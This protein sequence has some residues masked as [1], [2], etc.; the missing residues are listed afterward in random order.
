MVSLPDNPN[1]TAVINDSNTDVGEISDGHSGVERPRPEPVEVIKNAA[2]LLLGF[3]A[4]LLAGIAAAFVIAEILRALSSAYRR[5]LYNKASPEEKVRMLSDMIFKALYLR[6]IDACFGWKVDE[7]DEIISATVDGVKP[8]E[9]KRIVAIIEKTVYGG[10]APDGFE[11][12]T[13]V[14]FTEKVSAVDGNIF[15]VRFI[16]TR[17]GYMLGLIKK[18]A[19]KFKKKTV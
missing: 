6:D 3:V 1:K 8:E 16:K 5:H 14:T 12:R 9:Y 4:F 18:N 10:K 13:L 11:L 15:S 19:K 2:L 7:T 17:Y